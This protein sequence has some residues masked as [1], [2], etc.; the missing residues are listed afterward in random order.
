MK[1]IGI[2]LLGIIARI[3]GIRVRLLSLEVILL[4]GLLISGWLLGNRW[5][6]N[7]MPLA[8]TLD[9]NIWLLIL[10]SLICFVLITSLSAFI[11]QR[12]W[13]SL[14]LPRL[15]ALLSQFNSLALWQQLGFY[16]FCFALILLSA[17]GCLNA[18]C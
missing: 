2:K 18:I 3:P 16:Y 7:N 13:I 1:T 6:Q 4:L 9:P 15:S 8:G 17:I 11:M 5:M 12:I 14:G 10:L